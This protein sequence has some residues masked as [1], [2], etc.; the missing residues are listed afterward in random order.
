MT[1][2]IETFKRKEMK[3]VLSAAQMRHIV[4]QLDGR[5]ALDAFGRS[6]VSS[7]YFDTADR[8]LI[9]RSVEKPLYK[10]KLRVRW[11]GAGAGRH[12]ASGVSFG[13]A[14]KVAA[15]APVFTEMKKKFK[16]IV[17]KRRVATS[18]QAAQAWATGTAYRRACERFPLPDAA[19]QAEAL[20]AC[21]AQIA[22]E[23]DAMRARH[24][25][26]APSALITCERSAY[27]A[28]D[29]DLRITF[30]EHLRGCDLEA[31]PAPHHPDMLEPAGVPSLSC[32][33]GPAPAPRLLL[34]AG[35]AVMEVKSTGPLPLWLVHA[36]N[37]CA[38]RPS[39]FSKYGE[40]YKKGAHRC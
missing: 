38:A 18:A 22:R 5:M 14:Q 13:S 16:G 11:Y 28:P 24:G 30:D 7:V 37:E 40:L 35:S 1:A 36:M 12:A 2:Y 10:E 3:Y 27:T 4:E 21:S 20:S 33:R 15:D 26:L 29:T 32:A 8:S 17:Y 23:I 6:R 9:G 25:R 39:S 31:H 34:P 19:L